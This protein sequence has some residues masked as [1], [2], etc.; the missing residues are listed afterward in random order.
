MN[1]S[2]ILAILAAGTVIAGAICR[3]ADYVDT[4]SIGLIMVLGAGVLG[5]AAIAETFVSKK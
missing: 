4:R 5:L 1:R 3:S 2:M